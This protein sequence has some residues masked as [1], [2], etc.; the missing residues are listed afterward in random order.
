MMARQSFVVGQILEPKNRHRPHIGQVRIKYAGTTAILRAP[1]IVRRAT[2][3]LS[4]GFHPPNL[5]RPFRQN[6]EII[7]ELGLDAFNQVTGYLQV[8]FTALVGVLKIKFVT[9]AQVRKEVLQAAL[10]AYRRLDRL[11][12]S[13]NPGNLFQPRLVNGLGGQRQGCHPLQTVGIKSGAIRQSPS[14]GCRV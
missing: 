13:L 8:S 14:P 11:H 10:K 1:H 7:R 6:T 3:L 9:R 12:L 4:K 2:C 5:K